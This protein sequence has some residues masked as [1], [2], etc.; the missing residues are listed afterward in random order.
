MVDT[1]AHLYLKD[2]AGD[3]ADVSDRA[4]LNGVTEIYLPAIDSTEHGP[5]LELENSNPELYKAMMGLH[6]CSVKENYK[7][8]LAVVEEWLGKRKFYGIG[9]TGLDYYWDTTYKS[10]QIDAF[11]TQIRWAK[12]RG[13]PVI[14]HSR[15]AM[16][17]CIDLIE[18]HQ[19]GTLKGVFHCF[20]GS[21][22]QGKRIMAL[23]FFMG[24]GGGITYKKSGLAEVMAEMPLDKVVLETDAPYLTPVPYRGKRN[25]SCYLSYIS[26]ELAR[27]K[28]V[29]VEEIRRITTINA[30]KLFAS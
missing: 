23:D 7:D 21:V 30:K 3:I 10:Q 16:D 25:E 22:E 5:M 14:I 20:S 2:F 15:N 1:H 24:I 26:A 9:E 8:E 28:G 29:T 6:P 19:D 27:V 17:D 11:E 4:M 13:L 18:K 12:E